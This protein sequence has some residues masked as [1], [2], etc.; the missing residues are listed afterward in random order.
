[1]FLETKVVLFI[2]HFVQDVFGVWTPLEAIYSYMFI[3]ITRP[4]T[5]RDYHN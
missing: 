2:K 4:A 3:Y 1:M 5:V